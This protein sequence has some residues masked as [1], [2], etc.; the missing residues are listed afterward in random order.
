MIYY[1]GIFFT[2]GQTQER[3]KE[4]RPEKYNVWI[5]L[6]PAYT[7]S[8][9][10]AKQSTFRDNDCFSCFFSVGKMEILRGEGV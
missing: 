3:R 4:K 9:V 1:H 10:T 7:S 8:C 5:S 2:L 6:P